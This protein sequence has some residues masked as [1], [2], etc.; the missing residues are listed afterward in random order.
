MIE[1][2]SDLFLEKLITPFCKTIWNSTSIWCTFVTCDR[3]P[4][5]WPPMAHLWHK[6]IIII[7]AMDQC[8]LASVCV[9]RDWKTCSQK[10][11]SRTKTIRSF[12]LN[13]RGRMWCIYI[14]DEKGHEVI[15]RDDNC[16]LCYYEC[17]VTHTAIAGWPVLIHTA[18]CWR[19]WEPG[20]KLGAA[21][22]C[23][24]PSNYYW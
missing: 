9:Q 15:W 22:F 14:F 2:G 17:H 16:C 5:L 10:K 18:I 1:N 8:S 12:T 6:H 13:I 24:L 21:L 4:S 20:E 19:V 3:G 23:I 11:R 7:W